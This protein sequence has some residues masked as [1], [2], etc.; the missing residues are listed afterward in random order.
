ML[1]IPSLRCVMEDDIVE[2]NFFEAFLLPFFFCG[3]TKLDVSILKTT[4]G[5]LFT[6]ILSDIQSGA[7]G[8]F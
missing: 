3:L 1:M 2:L 7:L 6:L 8:G 5:I 4:Y